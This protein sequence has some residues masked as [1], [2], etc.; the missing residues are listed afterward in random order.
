MKTYQIE[1][2]ISGVIFGNYE[3]ETS[4][5]ALDAFARDAGYAD[6]QDACAQVPAQPGEIIAV[7]VTGEAVEG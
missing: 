3:G 5:H 6:Y 7:E 1:N 2:T 4:W